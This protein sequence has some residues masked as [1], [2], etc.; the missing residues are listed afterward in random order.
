MP[1]L[2]KTDRLTPGDHLLIPPVPGIVVAPS[3]RHPATIAKAIGHGAG[4]ST[5][6]PSHPNSLVTGQLLVVPNGVVPCCGR[7]GV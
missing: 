7:A 6:T 3:P 1:K 2:A 5:S 4:V